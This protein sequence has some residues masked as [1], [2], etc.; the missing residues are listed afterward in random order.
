M[1]PFEAG[2]RVSIAT[3]AAPLNDPMSNRRNYAT[4]DRGVVTE[5][6]NPAI[7]YVQFDKNARR[8]CCRTCILAPERPPNCV[9]KPA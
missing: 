6:G 4:G 9:E 2:D 3:M 1:K 5:S 8:E 7:V